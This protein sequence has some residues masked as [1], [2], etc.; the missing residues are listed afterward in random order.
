MTPTDIEARL[1]AHGIDRGSGL[2][3]YSGAKR[4]IFQRQWL[5]DSDRYDEH[6]NVI[7]DFL[8]AARIRPEA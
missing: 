2:G 5:A 6:I 1:V 8:Q 3:H 7:L 4:I